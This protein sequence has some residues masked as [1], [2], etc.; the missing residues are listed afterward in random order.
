MVV[1]DIPH[2]PLFLP[3]PPSTR[4][5]QQNEAGYRDI[6]QGRSRLEV[7]GGLQLLEAPAVTASVRLRQEMRYETQALFSGEPEH[8]QLSLGSTLSGRIDAVNASL[9]YNNYNDVSND[10]GTSRQ[11]NDLRFS[12]D[13]P[14]SAEITLQQSLGWQREQ[15]SEEGVPRDTLLYGADTSLPLLEGSLQSHLTLGYGVQDRAFN[16]L[17]VGANWFGLITLDFSLYFIGG[18]HLGDDAS[19][20]LLAG[21]FYQFENGEVLD[22]DASLHLSSAY[23]PELQLSLGYSLPFEVPLGRLE[24]QSPE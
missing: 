6:E 5:Y 21:G 8:Y 23:E 10:E 4:G 11:R 1:L 9:R 13:L 18:F 19:F 22:F 12:V 14:L 15:R 2:F 20:N 7:N 3:L 17:D 16:S 24:A